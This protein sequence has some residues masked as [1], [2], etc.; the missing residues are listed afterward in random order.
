MSRWAISKVPTKHASSL[1]PLQLSAMI[2]YVVTSP[3]CCHNV[4][5]LCYHLSSNLC[6]TCYLH[7]R[8]E[9]NRHEGSAT[10]CQRHRET[11]QHQ[12][13]QHLREN[14]K[15]HQRKFRRVR[16]M[17]S[18]ITSLAHSLLSC[19]WEQLSMAPTSSQQTTLS[20]VKSV[21]ANT[22]VR[23]LMTHETTEKQIDPK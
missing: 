16:S 18:I 3:Q 1:R 13:L 8:V 7:I 6:I 2:D 9:P 23:W 19:C 22:V 4:A 10:L 11:L 20:R 21:Y 15:R 17:R 14:N 12:Q 5:P